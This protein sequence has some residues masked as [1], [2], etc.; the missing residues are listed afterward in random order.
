MTMMETVSALSNA[1]NANRPLRRL[2]VDRQA[3]VIARGTRIVRLQPRE[4]EFLSILQAAYGRP[5]PYLSLIRMLW[6]GHQPADPDL[7]LRGYI[8]RARAALKRVGGFEIE[9]M[10]GVYGRRSGSCRLRRLPERRERG[11]A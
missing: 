5:V 3:S 10:R 7:A 2:I 11:S 4:V 6:Q 1:H 9:T 8:S